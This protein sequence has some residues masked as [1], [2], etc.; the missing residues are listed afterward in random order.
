MK[1]FYKVSSLS[2]KMK[3]VLIWL[4]FEIL[5]QKNKVGGQRKNVVIN[6]FVNGRL[7]ISTI[8]GTRYTH[9]CFKQFQLL[10]AFINKLDY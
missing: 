10:I 9:S 5:S 8:K 2:I 6:S 4:Q 3:L 7:I 1:V